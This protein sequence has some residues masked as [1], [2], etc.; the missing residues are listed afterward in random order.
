MKIKKILVA[1]LTL[2]LIFSVTS[3]SMADDISFSLEKMKGETSYT[4]TGVD[5]YYGMFKSL[6]EFPLNINLIKLGYSKQFSN[7]FF[8]DL[9][10]SLKKNIN[11]NAGIMKDSDWLYALSS[12]R[13]IYSES[14]ADLSA[15][16]FDINLEKEKKMTNLNTSFLIG[17]IYQKFDYSIHD[18]TQWEYP[19]YTT[20]EYGID[21]IIEIPLPGELLDYKV[22][23]KIPYLGIKLE[24]ISEGKIAWNIGL[25]YSPIVR[26][27]DRD[28][29]LL[30]YKLSEAQTS[31]NAFFVTGKVS[32]QVKGNLNLIGN[33]SYSKIDTSG[34]QSQY[35]YDGEYEGETVNNIACDIESNQSSLGVGI[36][37]EF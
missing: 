3:L 31:G 7:T 6:L 14:Q 35:W 26:A 29:H 10:L 36:E 1:I 17:Y 18:G 30:R 8:N 22:E 2:S 23:Y 9:N 11:N 32:L 28:D 20:I 12:N 19:P 13:S 27:N 4:I 25:K 33:L 24:N 21:S 15:Y 37:Y 34:N 16:M 5:S